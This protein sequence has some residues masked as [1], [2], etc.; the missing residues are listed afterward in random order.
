MDSVS[1][2]VLVG[3]FGYSSVYCTKEWGGGKS[4]GTPSSHRIAKQSQHVHIYAMTICRKMEEGE[5]T[6]E[7]EE[8]IVG[9][10]MM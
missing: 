5:H 1:C 3:T 7:K 9:M 10:T 8:L 6:I 4:S 2:S